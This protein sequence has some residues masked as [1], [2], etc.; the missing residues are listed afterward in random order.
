VNGTYQVGSIATSYLYSLK[1]NQGILDFLDLSASL[2]DYQAAA[3]QVYGVSWPTLRDAMAK[4]IRV[5]VAQ[6]PYFQVP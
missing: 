2:R 3:A 4:Y 6:T 1:G 5:V